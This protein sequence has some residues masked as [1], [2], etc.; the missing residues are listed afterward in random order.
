LSDEL[1]LG[2]GAGAEVWQV[3]AFFWHARISV[4]MQNLFT[5][6]FSPFYQ[7]IHT[8]YC[9]CGEH[10]DTNIYMYIHINIYTQTHTYAHMYI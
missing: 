5:T 8:N 6:Q 2:P 10:T 3:S 7:T 4:W 1:G 9:V